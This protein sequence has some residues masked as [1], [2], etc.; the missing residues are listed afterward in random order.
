MGSADLCF[1]SH[2]PIAAIE[3]HLQSLN[4]L[5]HVSDKGKDSSKKW[6]H[7]HFRTNHFAEQAKDEEMIMTPCVRTGAMGK[8]RSIYVRDPDRNLVEISHYEEGL[9]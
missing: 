4:Q 3:K 1:I 7:R 5:Y 8:I 9:Q 6:Q 2:H